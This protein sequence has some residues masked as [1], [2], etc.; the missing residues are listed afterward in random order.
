MWFDIKSSKNSGATPRCHL[1][2]TGVF[3]SHISPLA[4]ETWRKRHMDKEED[5]HRGIQNT[6]SAHTLLNK[7][8]DTTKPHSIT[9]RLQH[10]PI[11]R[12]GR[13]THTTNQQGFS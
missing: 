5:G 8:D 6:S 12:L 2:L 7:D 4:E 1:N 13:Y 3:T 9:L 11:Y 10:P